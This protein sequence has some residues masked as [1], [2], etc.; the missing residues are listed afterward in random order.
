MNKITGSVQHFLNSSFIN[1]QLDTQNLSVCVYIYVF[2]YFI[3]KIHLW[4]S[5]LEVGCNNLPCRDVCSL[6]RQKKLAVNM[7][8]DV[9]AAI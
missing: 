9:P 1:L 5:I 4:P 3:L 8:D 7:T 2:I 6:C